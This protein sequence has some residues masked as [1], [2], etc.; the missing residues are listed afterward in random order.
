MCGIIGFIGYFY[1][2]DKTFDGLRMLLNRGYDSSGCIWII[3]GKIIAS[4]YA[5]TKDKQSIELVRADKHKSEKAM[6]LI[7]HDRW[8]TT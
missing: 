2:F 4:K 3:D 7:A 5:N 6:T 8:S 1:G